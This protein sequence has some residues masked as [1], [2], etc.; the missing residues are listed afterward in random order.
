MMDGYS[1]NLMTVTTIFRI[2]C[3][4]KPIITSTHMM[5]LSSISCNARTM[6]A[7]EHSALRLL[8]SPPSRPNGVKS[9]NLKITNMITTQLDINAT[10]STRH[11][12]LERY[13]SN[14]TDEEW[15]HLKE[16]VY[17]EAQQHG[18]HGGFPITSVA[19]E[20]L[21]TQGFD[22][23]DV[24]DEQMAE[25][26]DQMA[27]AYCDDAFWVELEVIAEDM[28]IPLAFSVKRRNFG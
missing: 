25:I 1:A 3:G 8:H 12:I 4:K 11:A 5:S 6:Q 18:F 7:G 13:L 2:D 10:K 24:T 22:T 16:A 9:T 17:R 14:P 15:E 19:R 21:E 20:D 23:S 28:G 27:D 26:A